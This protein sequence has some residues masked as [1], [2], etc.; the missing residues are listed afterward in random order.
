[1]NGG[2]GCDVGL[3]GVFAAGDGAVGVGVGVGRWEGRA[4]G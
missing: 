3:C 4:A 2:A 1:M